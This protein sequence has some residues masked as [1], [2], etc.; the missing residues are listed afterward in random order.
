M[1][2]KRGWKTVL[3]DSVSVVHEK[4]NVRLTEVLVWCD[5]PWV[6]VKPH[7]GS[8]LVLS[9]VE[10][11]DDSVSGEIGHVQA[12]K[13]GN[14]NELEIH[15]GLRDICLFIQIVSIVSK[16]GGSINTDERQTRV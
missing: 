14:R 2:G 4:S 15:I 8:E 11:V 6:R 13:R 5:T 3:T 12:V 10:A 16:L 7:H 1:L 9:H